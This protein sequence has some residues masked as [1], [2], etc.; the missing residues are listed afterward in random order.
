MKFRLT[1]LILFSLCLSTVCADEGMWLLGNLK[2]NK[3]TDEVMKQLGLQVPVSKLYN[4]KKPALSDA[5][6]S[7]GGFC[8]GVV[9]SEDGLVFTNHH[10]GFSS[11]QQHSSVAHNYLKDGFAARS[12]EEELPNPEL[13]VRFLLRT[14]NVTKRVLSAAKHAKTAS[15]RQVAVDSVTRAIGLEVSAKDSTLTGIVDAYYAGN[16]FWL[17]VYR[18]Y[19]DVRL[20]FAPPSSVGKFGWDT[21]NWMWPRH[22]GD[23]SV[24]RIYANKQNGPAD[25]SPDNVPYHPA[26]VAPISLAGYK[27]GSFCMTLG[28]PGSTERFLSSYGIEE[29]MD[30]INQAMIDVRGV[31]QAIW[32]REMDRRPDIRIKYASKYDESSNY[33]KNSI[34]TN[35]SIRQLKIVEK[36][37]AAEAALGKWIQSHS[38][39]RKKLLHLFSSLELNYGN[40]SEINRALAYF[41]E[42]F[43]NGPEL[44]QLALETLNFDFDAEQKQVVSSMKKLLEKYKNLDIAIDKEVF[45]A[46]LKE[47]Q[48]KVDKKYL[49]AM[50]AKIDTLY[51]GNIQA[52][53]DSLYATSQL[54]SPKG[55]KRF[56]DRD[57]TYHLI[58]DPAVSLSLDLIVNYYEMNQT[59]AGASEQIEKDERLFN[60]AMR[61]MYADRHFYPDANSTMRLSFGT[62][63]GYS[64]FDGV[65]Y[66]YYTTVKGIFE[67][68]KEHAGNPDFAVQP[69]L[70]NLLASGNF[71]RYANQQ[72]DMNVCFISNNDITGGNSGSAMFNSKGELIG[73]AFD[74]NWEAMS[75]DVMFNPELQRCIGVDIRYILFMI[76]KYGKATNLI[77]E[78]S[79][80]L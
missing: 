74:G 67:K 7:F 9:V 58:D 27:E 64:P 63:E 73:L 31:K 76:E 26:Y 53:A 16:E 10:C 8:S 3:Q 5:I 75:S 12:L 78:L 50:Y 14:E 1:A 61:R 55:F 40:R 69:E 52:Y 17:S 23:F 45:V 47:Y 39:E 62:V 51:N 80:C 44:I 72:G 46:M 19:N 22:T 37:R 70:L 13:Y 24:F 4:P 25:Y 29:R 79:I 60:A 49:P 48:S 15:E 38:E 21:D 20:V 30:G 65:T 35:Q 6:V 11:I 42:A 41:G 77:K 43:M 32:K 33:W 34:G 71:G 36:K 59:I 18:D 28:Y 66:G 56:L 57:T 54:T 68:V 2:K